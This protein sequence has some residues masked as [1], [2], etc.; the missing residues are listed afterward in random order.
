MLN[1]SR[2]EKL[3][4]KLLR[5]RQIDIALGSRPTWKLRFAMRTKVSI[6]GKNQELVPGNALVPGYIDSSIQ[7]IFQ[8]VSKIFVF[9]ISSGWKFKV[10][11]LPVA[12]LT[13]LTYVTRQL[14]KA[15]F[16]V[17]SGL[18]L[19]FFGVSM[20]ELVQICAYLS[21][22]QRSEISSI[23]IASWQTHGIDAIFVRG[24]LSYVFFTLGFFHIFPH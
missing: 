18:F 15:C 7:S 2:K 17:V 19:W 12:S 24:F 14:L 22:L 21:R 8:G 1:I 5:I 13:A 4:S 3:N 16:C 20:R 6:G 9:K 11:Q 23:S 10:S